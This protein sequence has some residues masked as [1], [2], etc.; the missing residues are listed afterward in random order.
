MADQP[1]FYRGFDGSEIP[2]PVVQGSRFNDEDLKALRS[3]AEVRVLDLTESRV[4][5]EGLAVLGTLPNLEWLY[6]TSVS[7][8]TGAGLRSIAQCPLI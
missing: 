8:V 5:D 3:S 7:R 2:F 1:E 6:L 4:T